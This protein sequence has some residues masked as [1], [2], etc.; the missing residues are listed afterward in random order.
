[1][2]KLYTDYEPRVMTNV[3]HPIGAPGRRPA[4]TKA[5]RAMVTLDLLRGPFLAAFEAKMDL[6]VD[7]YKDNAAKCLIVIFEGM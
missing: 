6:A 4:L 2:E 1:M 3:G 7:L 5:Q